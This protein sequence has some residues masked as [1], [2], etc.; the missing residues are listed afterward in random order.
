MDLFKRNDLVVSH[1]YQ[2]PT[3]QLINP[4]LLARDQTMGST[5]ARTS[6]EIFVHLIL[7]LVHVGTTV[8][9]NQSPAQR[10]FRKKGP[11][12][13]TKMEHV[14]EFEHPHRS[15]CNIVGGVE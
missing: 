14:E 7:P 3:S 9:S 1:P 12:F 8:C 5:Y 11:F 15:R 10:S 13:R 4:L 2:N 6:D